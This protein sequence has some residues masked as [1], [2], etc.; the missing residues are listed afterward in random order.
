MKKTITKILVACLLFFSSLTKAQFNIAAGSTTYSQDFNTLTSG[1]WTDNTTLTGWYAKTDA[2]SSITAYVANTGSST[3]AGLNAFGVAGTNAL[4]DRAI[5]Y[6][7]SNAYTGTAGT[8]KGYIGWRLKNNT[9][10]TITSL[11]VI[12]SGEQWRRDNATAQNLVLSYQKGTTVTDLTAGTWTTT[13]ST[14]TSPQLS[15]TAL[16]LDGN[17]PANRTSGITISISVTINAGEEIMLRWEDLNDSGNDH[18]LAV[19]DVSVSAVI[20][21]AIT[22]AQDGLWTST[23]TWVG[24]SVP[25]SS[26]NVVIAHTVTAGALTR[27]SGTTTTINTTGNLKVSGAYSAIGGTTTVNGAFQLDA[28]GY[29]VS[30]TNNFT[31]GAAGTLIFNNTGSYGVNNTDAYWPSTGGPVNVTVLQ[32]GFQLNSASRT[33]T[34]TLATASGVALSSSTLTLN[35]TT[36]LNS[37]GFFSNTPV[38]GSASTLVYNNTGSITVGNEWTGNN[39]T[40]GAGIPQNVTI[41]N[42]TT[43]NMPSGNRGLAGNLSISSGTLSLNAAGDLYVGGNWTRVS[44]A[45]FAPNDKGVFFNGSANQTVTVSPSGT[46]FFNYLRLSGLSLTL[47]AGTD[48]EVNRS[49]GLTLSSTLILGSQTLTLSAG[50]NLDLNA[51]N[52]MITSTAGKISITNSPLTV[53]NGGTLTSDANTLI[54]L[55]NGINFGTGTTTFWTVNGTLQL[56]AVG[57]VFGNSPKYGSTSLLQYNNGAN[58]F[59]RSL[60]WTS[61]PA[62][63]GTAGYPNNVQLSN[64]TILNY[65]NGSNSGAKGINGNLV[66]DSGS[67]LYMDYGSTSSGGPLSVGGNI[68]IAGFFSL[69]F[70]SGDDLK[71]GGNFTNTGTFVPNARAVFFTKSG[72]QTVSSS[73]PLTFP[74]VVFQPASGGTTVQLLSSLSV[75]APNAGNAIAFNS[76]SD[77]FDLNGFT[78]TLGTAGVANTISGSG[79]FKGSTTSNMTLRGTGSVGTLNFTTGSQSLGT[80]TVTRTSN[81]TGLTL[82]T[83]LLVNSLLQLNSGLVDIAGNNLT[84]GSSATIGNYSATE[85]VLTN[86][87]GELRKTFTAI[88]SFVFPVGNGGYTP[89]TLNFSAGSFSSAYAGMRSTALKHPSNAATTDYI[90]RYWSLTSSGITSPTYSFT[91]TY[92]SSDIIGTEVNSKPGRYDGSDWQDI[93]TTSISSNT[94]TLSGLS[95]LSAV[96][97]FSA[98]NPLSTSTYYYR[99][100]VSGA[101]STA[102]NWQVSANNSTGWTTASTPPSTTAAGINIR[103]GF[104][105][106]NSG[107]VTA[108]D[109]LIDA[110][111]TLTLS[112]G[113]FTLNNGA[114]ATD[115]NVNGTLTFSG[116]TFTQAASSGT[117]FSAGSTY[118]HAII[119]SS[120]TL[121]VATWNST[122]TCNITGLTISSPLTGPATMGQTFGNLIWNNSGQT[123]SGYV[124]IQNSL[125]AVAG[126]LTVS[127]GLLSMATGSGTFNNTINTL[128]VNGGLFNGVGATGTVNLTVTNSVTVASLGSFN[129][130]FG[131]GN[132]NLSIGTDLIISG[133]ADFTLGNSTG[134]GTTTVGND[135]SVSG[136]SSLLVAYGSATPQTLTIGRDL[137]IS[138]VDAGIN[139][140]NFT[141]GG[142]ATINVGRDFNCSNTGTTYAAVDFGAGTVSSNVI[143]ITRN[144]IKSGTGFF[145]TTSTTGA[146]GFSFTGTGTHTFTYSGAN[147]NFTSYIV[148]NGGTLL[149]NTSLTLGTGTAPS[150]LFTVEGGATL[151]FQT[152]SIIAGSTTEPRFI[153]NSGSSLVT[154]STGGIGGTTTTGSLRSFGSTNSTTGAGVA[155]LATGVNYTFNGNTL[156]PFSA[157]TFGNPA[158]VNV[159][160]TVTSNM[161]ANLIVSTAVNVNNGGTFKLNPANNN[162]LS[163]TSPAALNIAVGGIFDNG[164]EN[165]VMGSGAI[166]VSGSF[167]TQDM[168]GFVGTNTSIPGIT[169]VLN[170]GSTV[171]YGRAGNQAVQGG[172]APT[173]QNVTFSNSGTKTLISG[174]DVAGTI[175]ISGSAVLDADNKTFGVAGTNL[176]MT[177]T[178]VYRLG[179]SGTK[180]DAAGTYTLSPTSTIEFYGTSATGIRLGSTAYNYANMIVNGTNVSNNGTATGIKFQSG[181]TFTVKNGATFK[182]NNTAGFTGGTTTAIN[183]TNNPTVT[184]ETGSTIEYAGG[185]QSLTPFSPSYYNLAVSGTGTK[186][187]AGSSEILVGNNLA[188]TASTLQIDTDKLLTVTNAINNTSGNN[189][190][191]ANG[192]NLVQITDVDNA[193]ANNNTGNIK[194][195]RTTRSMSQNDYVYWGAPIKQSPISQIPSAYIASYTWILNGSLDGTWTGASGVGPGNG[196]ITRVSGSG[197]GVQ[198]FDFTGVPNNGIV[199]VAADSYDNGATTSATGNTVL[200]GNPYPSAISASSLVSMNSSLAGTL[201]FWT[202]LTPITNNAYSYGDYA[203]WNGT[204]ATAPNDTS[205]TNALRPTGMIAAGQGFFAAL[206]SDAGVTFSN[207]MRL[208]TTTDNNQFFRNGSVNDSGHVWLDL[209]GQNRFRQ[210]LVGYV[211]GATNGYESKFD[212]QSFCGSQ[213]DIYSILSGQ[214]LNIQGRGL[215]FDESDIVPLGVKVANA[216]TYTIA[217]HEKDGFLSSQNIYIEDLQEGVIHDLNAS[218]YGFTTTS[219]TFNDRFLLRYTTE[220][221][222]TTVP[223]LQNTL[224]VATGNDKLSLHSS[225]DNISGIRVFD[226]SGRLIFE[227]QDISDKDFTIK[228]PVSHQAVIVRV[229][230]A[231]GVVETRK[232]IL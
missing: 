57:Y 144:F 59:S 129:V 32:G 19:D 134:T 27:N 209:T 152:N 225:V 85:Y 124:N 203:T 186:T 131:T 87:T 73:S 168:D 95:T 154:S 232:V 14:F 74:Y 149:L 183:N 143:N 70:S 58:P 187:I 113:S 16:V 175:T 99:S 162:N 132:C 45:T 219:G 140:K 141:G 67:A 120:L 118:N 4:T 230:F 35:G 22:S 81:V 195:T 178:S 97:Q 64:N 68:S 190:I 224:Q 21:S 199:T 173:Y 205:G 44:T 229:T 26:D 30:S 170:T 53:T 114:A 9:G 161:T 126:T 185:T 109:I 7:P 100:A 36:Q 160:A 40:A 223:E 56:N 167:I 24:G 66:I 127:Q 51:G 119:S 174:N 157:G 208:R 217:I 115:M 130:S 98:G 177:G 184:L 222:G 31:Y 181:G 121:P 49:S 55:R 46:E 150:S 72:T 62:T 165:Q 145:Y 210:M 220:T 221:L 156:T 28:G 39:T 107:T 218:P 5:G 23:S 13:T 148:R 163:L 86:S 15:A 116:G 142:A 137:L 231:D 54:D 105:I 12:W 10:S 204:G 34:G 198:N 196:F 213:I 61:A 136:D 63:L 96:N 38:F 172:T 182:L 2:T 71:I 17:T 37:G 128:V 75:T 106:T 151:N 117:T 102:S 43:V 25:T 192:G 50:G 197:T 155:T 228:K 88:G 29:T 82:G 3:T 226:L 133:T 90:S 146:I 83:S 101:W 52:R 110:G 78:L 153:T 122:S 227:K 188:V 18:F 94:L 159:N 104:N 11:N 8:G 135:V 1:T 20:S 207:A 80:L 138:G 211:E 216:G 180:P 47:A 158:T 206:S 41:Q 60:E 92:L 108:D 33:I 193:T 69:G 91:G 212:G 176:T 76:A 93:S 179:G 103:N 191:V 77:V 202:S 214:K 201:Y 42:S 139:M 171:E 194:I 112:G 79:T 89:A 84:L 166:N 200:L 123:A 164:G 169:P 6:S 65:I 215:P 125:F 48:I 111:A 147:S 189:I